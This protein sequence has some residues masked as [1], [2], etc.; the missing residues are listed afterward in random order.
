MQVHV[1][2]GGGEGLAAVERRFARWRKGRG[3]NG[4]IPHELWRAAAEAAVV[5]GVRETAS[6]LGLDVAR[7][8]QWTRAVGEPKA[9]EAPP[10]FVELAPLALGTTA[11]CTLETEDAAGRK[12]RICL[13]GPATAQAL[14]LGE[15]LWRGQP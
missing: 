14:Q 11:E 10:Q 2:G 1:R 13:K 6:R 9:V 7:L 8:R 3:G 15:M 5:C 4:R 12:L